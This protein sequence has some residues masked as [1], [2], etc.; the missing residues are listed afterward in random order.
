GP[1]AKESFWMPA[2]AGMSGGWVGAVKQASAPEPRRFDRLAPEGEI[3]G[4]GG[5]E[6]FWRIA[7]GVDPDMREPLDV[8]R[9][10]G[11]TRELIRNGRDDGSR[12]SGRRHQPVPGGG[13]EGRKAGFDHG[14]NVG[15]LLGALLA[16][17]RQ[18]TNGAG[19]G[20]AERIREIGE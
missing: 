17:H 3:G 10:L 1:R 13:L 9:V 5:G 12:R 15:E 6:L 8:F 11:R 18:Q 19:A 2:F 14:R 16:R 7:D 20:L 4:D